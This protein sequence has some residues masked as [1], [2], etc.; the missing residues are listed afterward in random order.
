MIYLRL[1][2]AE[3]QANPS[4]LDYLKE[5]L[6]EMTKEIYRR[7]SKAEKAL[8]AEN[9]KKLTPLYKAKIGSPKKYL[10]ALLASLTYTVTGDTLTIQVSPKDRYYKLI[11]SIELGSLGIKATPILGKVLAV[12][13]SLL[14]RLYTDYE[15]LSEKLAYYQMADSIKY[16]LLS[17][18]S[19]Y[20]LSD[21][22]NNRL[23]LL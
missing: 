22:L 12:L 19:L 6:A 23:K 8:L 9:L 16:K 20:S 10:E 17:R 13:P 14:D 18:Y 2:L 3:Y 15:I 4:F 7:R 5:G 11:K 1:A 21:R